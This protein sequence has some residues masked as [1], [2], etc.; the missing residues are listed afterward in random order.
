MRKPRDYKAEYARRMAKG[1]AQGLTRNQARGH[2]GIG[3]RPV[4]R[5]QEPSPSPAYDP[6]LEEG[7]RAM[8]QGKRLRE[9]ARYAHVAPERLRHYIGQSQ[10]AKKERGRWMF[11]HD[12]I[13]RRMLIYSNGQA[14]E[15]QVKGSE[16]A[17]LIGRYMSAV[18]RFLETNDA[19]MLSPFRGVRVTDANGRR[20]VLETRPNVLYRLAESGDATFEQIY[21][22]VI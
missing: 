18:G 4:S 22:I 10:F 12:Q 19:S 8:L 5:L 9:A 3:E 16:S 21:R 2:P 13:I 15:I 7:L 1:L 17:S 6:R 14:F 11:R 20:Y